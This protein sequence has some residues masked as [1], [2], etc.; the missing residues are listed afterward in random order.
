MWLLHTRT[1]SFSSWGTRRVASDVSA[2]EAAVRPEATARAQT[3]L[4]ID[5][6]PPPTGSDAANLEPKGPRGQ[7]QIVEVGDHLD[8]RSWRRTDR[9]SVGR[10][11]GGG[12][13][14]SQGFR[15]ARRTS[16]GHSA[17]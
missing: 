16:R 7:G 6:G 15:E 8:A 4:G 12:R 13:R 1:D 17:S 2:G 3:V 9:L 5:I 14:R 11:D 10:D